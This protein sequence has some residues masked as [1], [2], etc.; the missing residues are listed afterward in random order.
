MW[1]SRLAGFVCV[2]GLTLTSNVGIL[3]VVSAVL[4]F[5]IYMAFTPQSTMTIETQEDFSIL[6]AAFAMTNGFA[7]LCN[8]LVP[9]VFTALTN[10]T[11]SMLTAMRIDGFLLLA[12]AAVA[13]FGLKETGKKKGETA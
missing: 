10:A 2:I 12:A 13:L 11:G 9:S 6:G 1:I 7:L 5:A 4:G 8:L 3:T